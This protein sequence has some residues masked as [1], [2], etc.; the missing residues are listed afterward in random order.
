MRPGTAIVRVSPPARR[1]LGAQTALATAV[2]PEPLFELEALLNSARSH[3]VLHAL[4]SVSEANVI[5]RDTKRSRAIK[6]FNVGSGLLGR[7][8]KLVTFLVL[9]E[10]KRDLWFNI[11]V[12]R[13]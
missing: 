12:M 10:M 5:S 1:N 9:I 13:P 2:I 3:P 4:S 6:N 8:L 11:V 7:T